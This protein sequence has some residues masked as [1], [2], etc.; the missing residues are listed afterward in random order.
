[1]PRRGWRGVAAA[2]L[3]AVAP[4]VLGCEEGAPASRVGIRT[5]V[6]P[7]VAEVIHEDLDKH[8]VGVAKAAEVLRRG[9]LIE[10][11]AERES[12]MRAALRYVQ[13]PP[14]GIAE[15]IS[16]PMSFLA[17]VGADGRVIARD[18]EPDRMR[19]MD[20]AATFPV[21]KRALEEGMPGYALGE[22]GRENEEGE[23]SWS[24]LFVHPVRVGDDGRVVGAVVAGIPLWREAQRLSRQLRVER[25][26]EIEQGLVLW[27]YLYKGDRIFHFATP[28]DLDEVAPDA[29]TRAAG[30]ARSPG[31]FTGEVQLLGRWYGYGVVPV[32]SIAP[33]VGMIVFRSEPPG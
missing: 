11:P 3:V 12:Q 7:R 6:V 28:P 26:A 8:R 13:E 4:W 33:D 14:R 20:F 25:A 23:T 9:F 32:P 24:M 2:L 21:V 29:A 10:D 27:V 5:E 18:A 31:G 17:A 30:L 15:F 19:G 16:T 1:M 22:F